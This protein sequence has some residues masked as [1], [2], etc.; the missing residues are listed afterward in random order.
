MESLLMLSIANSLVGKR[1][2]CKTE[3]TRLIP[4]ITNLKQISIVPLLVLFMLEQTYIYWTTHFQQS[5]V[6]LLD[7]SLIKSL[8]QPDY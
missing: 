5:I 3:S 6:M 2:E 7:T 4:I 1:L 8:G